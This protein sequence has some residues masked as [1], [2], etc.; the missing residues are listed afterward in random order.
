MMLWCDVIYFYKIYCG[1]IRQ[2]FAGTGSVVVM[3]SWIEHAL[4]LTSKCC[5][6][7]DIACRPTS[8]WLCTSHR[9]DSRVLMFSAFWL[10]FSQLLSVLW[11][12]TA[13]HIIRLFESPD[14]LPWKSLLLSLWVLSFLFCTEFLCYKC[15]LVRMGTVPRSYRRYDYKEK[16][17]KKIV[18]AKDE[19]IIT[20]FFST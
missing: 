15:R 4:M 8:T 6:W 7:I 3:D 17:C 1:G 11:K 2:Y 10:E 5:S 9:L 20:F 18:P 19:T 16:I 13:I 14:G 12:L